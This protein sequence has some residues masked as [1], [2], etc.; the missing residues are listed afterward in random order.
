MKRKISG[1]GYYGRIGYKGFSRRN[2][3]VEIY[4]KGEG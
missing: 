1:F 3:Q 2:G 4:F